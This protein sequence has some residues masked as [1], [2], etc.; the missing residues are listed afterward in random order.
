M[1]TEESLA[2]VPLIQAKPADAV[3]EPASAAATCC[4]AAAPAKVVQQ[5]EAPSAGGPATAPIQQQPPQA[6]SS[7][8]NLQMQA[9]Q[10]ES[11]CADDFQ[12]AAPA[13]AAAQ[14]QQPNPHQQ[15]DAAGTKSTHPKQ[16]K[17]HAYMQQQWR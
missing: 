12:A 3:V 16:R 4:A 2:L 17:Q 6:A 14:P 15:K 11:R 1:Q 7:V 9:P 5:D 13:A 8:L 10:R